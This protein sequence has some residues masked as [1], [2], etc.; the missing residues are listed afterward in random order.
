MGDWNMH[1]V[2]RLYRWNDMGDC[3]EYR[4]WWKGDTIERKADIDVARMLL[5]RAYRR[6]GTCFVEFPDG[7]LL[8]HGTF[9]WCHSGEQPMCPL[10]VSAFL[11]AVDITAIVDVLYTY[12]VIPMDCENYR[13]YAG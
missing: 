3:R 4:E 2:G 5:K 8:Y 9:G 10:S 11:F 6:A 12:F 7:M 13:S 1:G